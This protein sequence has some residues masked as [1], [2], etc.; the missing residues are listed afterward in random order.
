[1]TSNSVTRNS[2][3]NG[4]GDPRKKPLRVA[5]AG[6]PNSGKTTLFNALTGMRY[7]VANYPG[8]TVEKKEGRT[9]LPNVGEVIFCD[10]PGTYSI[11]GGSPDELVAS[12]FLSGL[13]PSEE[14]PDLIICVIDTCN[15][16]RNLY[17]ASQLKDQGRP[18]ILALSM[19]DLALRDGIHIRKEL[20]ARNFGAQVVD[21]SGRNKTDLSSLYASLSSI[22]PTASGFDWCLCPEFIEH[23]KTLGVRFAELQ[24]VS[25]SPEQSIVLGM[26]LLTGARASAHPALETQVQT[27]REALALKGISAGSVET[28]DR[29]AWISSVIAKS[30]SFA[31]AE[32]NR[33]TESVDRILT[34]KLWGGLVFLGIMALVFQ[35]IFSWAEAPMNLIDDGISY[36]RSFVS[37]WLPPGI[38]RSLIVDGIISGVGSVLVFVPQIVILFFFIAVL[39]ESGYLSRA[40]FMMDNL[41]RRFGLQGRSFIPLLSSFACAVPGIL[42][43]RSIPSWTDRMATILVAPLMS[44]SARLPVYTLLIAAFIPD[45]ALLGFFS[46]QGLT[47]L[48]MYLLG[49]F[50]AG[51]IALLLKKTLFR[52]SSTHFVMEMPP[53]RMPQPLN[54]LRTV[55]DRVLL[56]LKAAGTIILACS[57]ILWFLASFPQREGASRAEAVESSYAGRL[58]HLIE[59]V[60]K[61]LGFDWKFGVGI[62]ASFAARE[63]FVSS[64]AMLHNLEEEEPSESLVLAVKNERDPKTGKLRYTPLTAISLMVFFVFSCQCMSTLAVCRRETGSWRWMAF[65]FAYMTAMAYLASL[66][67]YQLGSRLF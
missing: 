56:F 65:M 62:V 11:F 3:P 41:M 2:L 24:K 48:A 17:L 7:K 16:E 42:S 30:V 47:L 5:I 40:A 51:M 37:S 34:H 45:T 31:S 8:V 22:P 12:R 50:G 27:A 1:M 64:T 4:S 36:F 60:I 39:E 63:V 66:A 26:S 46:L 19:N 54:I 57:I 10:L 58:G 21:I 15:L 9:V 55:L 38:L 20:L 61:P 28:R 33:G 43:T 13:I 14:Q 59:P 44:C 18:L 53:Y 25:A 67:T 29:Y 23:S 52:G 6:V 32:R 35:A 49:A